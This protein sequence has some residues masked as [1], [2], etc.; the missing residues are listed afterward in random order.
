MLC[1][2]GCGRRLTTRLCTDKIWHLAYSA[3]NGP[4]ERCGRKAKG[5]DSA[6]HL[7][8]KAHL[9]GW[10]HTQGLTAEFS[11]PEP[12]GSAVLVRLEDGRVL[13]AHLDR[14]RPVS[15]DDSSREVILGPGVRIAPDIL[16]QR[17][18]VQRIRFEDRPGARLVQGCTSPGAQ[19]RAPGPDLEEE[20]E[21]VR[22]SKAWYT[23]P[24]RPGAYQRTASQPRASHRTACPQPSHPPA[25]EDKGGTVTGSHES[26]GLAPE[27]RAHLAPGESR[28]APF[29]R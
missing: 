3:S 28:D 19:W 29:G 23:P 16:E 8:A 24:V 4:V 18:Y 11:C 10:L 17:G 14:N 2:G 1:E 13:L 26:H 9:A 20:E 21:S 15:R 25:R 7:F 27:Q 5:K 6:N 22:L 12:L